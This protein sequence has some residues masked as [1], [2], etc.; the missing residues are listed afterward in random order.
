MRTEL[1]NVITDLKS[2]LIFIEDEIDKKILSEFIK[3][4]S[5]L[6]QSF[7]NLKFTFLSNKLNKGYEE[8]IKNF[9]FT[10]KTNW[11]RAISLEKR[12]SVMG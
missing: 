5:L 11:A 12:K 2:R 8:I 4:L 1:L 7:T 10:H 6:K 3:Q 9:K